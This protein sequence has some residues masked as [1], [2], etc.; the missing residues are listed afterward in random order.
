MFL[1]RLSAVIFQIAEQI[2][3]I[4]CFLAE[5]FPGGLNDIAGQ[6]QLF[7]N[8]EGIAL[9][10]DTDGQ[11]VGG[12]QGLHIEFAGGV[13]D[14]VRTQGIDLEFTVM[15]SRQSADSADMHEIEDTD[16]QGRAFRGIG[17]GTQ[18]VE[19]AQAVFIYPAEDIHDGRHMG[20]EGGQALF[21]ALLISDIREDFPEEGKLTAV[22]G[23]NVEA[24]H[25]HQLK[26]ADRL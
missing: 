6:A 23:R 26:E 2:L 3:K 14:A 1:L 5:L 15:R 8:R 25:A 9:A 10:G 17:A 4:L 7:G 13:F 21:N 16:G 19:Q 20:G 24:G 11:A 18:L 12:L 22:P